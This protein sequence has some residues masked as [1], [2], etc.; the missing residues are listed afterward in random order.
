MKNNYVKNSIFILVVAMSVVS[1]LTI[2]LASEKTI[3]NDNTK[4]ITEIFNEVDNQA[5]EIE[6]V[7][8]IVPV[9]YSTV[10]LPF[11]KRIHPIT[12]EERFHTG[13][14][15]VAKEGTKIK[16]AADGIVET[17]SYDTEK[18]NYVEIKHIDGSISS[19]HHGLEILVEVGQNVKC[20]EEIMTVGKTGNATGAHLHFEVRNANN[21]YMD[22]NV[23]V[24]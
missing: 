18:G 15:L 6:K 11:G 10:S 5:N 8:Y 7:E 13:I 2:S 12:K 24:D 17:A 20:G 19:Y 14:D 9:E 4:I 21:E 23:L 16:A 3:N 1:L 22:V